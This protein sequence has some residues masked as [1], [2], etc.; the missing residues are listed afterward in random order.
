MHRDSAL[1]RLLLPAAVALAAAGLAACGGGGDGTAAGEEGTTAE[2]GC[3]ATYALPV[4]AAEL[5][6][7]GRTVR[8]AYSGPEPCQFAATTYN[9]ELFIE[10]RT[11]TEGEPTIDP[12]ELSGCVQGELEEPLPAGTP[13]EPVNAGPTPI[14]GSELAQQ[15]HDLLESSDCAE[16]ARGEA[17]FTVN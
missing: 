10:L 2:A 8:M 7:D 11:A 9:G 15:G 6:A 16:V 14:P 3:T 12:S 4:A 13:V 17:A 5:D 1:G